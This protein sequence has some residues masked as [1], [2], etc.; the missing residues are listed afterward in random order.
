MN[1]SVVFKNTFFVYWNQGFLLQIDLS[2]TVNSDT[3]SL[4]PS[5]IKQ[6]AKDMLFIVISDVCTIN[7]INECKW[8]H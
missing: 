5:I 7:I 1:L 3:F 6:N 8:Q 2:C 4:V